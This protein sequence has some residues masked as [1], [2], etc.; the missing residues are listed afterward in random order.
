MFAR[1]RM[2]ALAVLVTAVGLL[3]STSLLTGQSPSSA[4]QTAEPKSA[5]DLRSPQELNAELFRKFQ[6]ELLFLAQKLERSERPEDKERAKVIFAALELAKK[7]NVENQFQK[8]VAGLGKGGTNL[9][10]LDSV[11]GQDAQLTKVLQEILSI[12]M[13]DDAATVLKQERERLEKILAE[14][15]DILRN[16]KT[17]RAMTD[18]ERVE[19]ARIAKDQNQVT[20]RTKELAKRL[21]SEP[22]DAGK[23][24]EGIAK[25][26]PKPEAK[27]GD[28]ESAAKPDTQQSKSSSKDSKGGD[29]MKPGQESGADKKPVGKD[30]KSANGDDKASPE[31][32]QSD[33]A[34]SPRDSGDQEGASK[35][36]ASKEGASKEGKE[37]SSK[38]AAGK[39]GSNKEGHGK[40]AAGKPTSKSDG[41]GQGQGKGQ[42][43]PSPD[44]GGE[45]KGSNAKEGE[46]QQAKQQGGAKGGGQPQPGG[47]PQQGAQQPGQQ[48]Q[49]QQ[50]A[51]QPGRKQLQDAYPHQKSSEDDLKKDQREQA[52]KQQEKAIEQI[53]K[54]IQ[55]LEKKIKQLREE[56]MLK[57]LANLEVRVNRMLAMQIEVYEATKA[58]DSILLKNNGVK[59]TAEVQKSQQQADKEIDIIAEAEKTLKLLESEGTAVAFAR[60]LEE[61]RQD[62]IAVQRRLNDTYVGKDTQEV[63]EN[64]I[65]MLKEMLLALKKAQQDQQQQ[66]KQDQQQQQPQ[67]P[68]DKKLIEQVAELKLIRTLQMNVNSR[69][70]GTGERYK[71]EQASS[72]IIQAE[73][74]Q[75]A[76]KQ[77][78]LQDMVNKIASGSNQ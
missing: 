17:I 6:R 9:Q 73:L 3:L 42:D 36:G 69:T 31:D 65:T 55:E 58:I 70:K 20:D 41:K 35:E 60:V 59:T 14:A 1:S 67:K 44:S 57:L 74:R 39:E 56:E 43:K 13:T 18:V 53:A 11:S 4:P 71:G 77:A 28:D 54:A 2:I 32:K 30:A 63:E 37:G 38:D 33:Q 66:Q 51:Q 50:Q 7:E 49:H 25:A 76:D 24:Q 68:G 29:P 64:V 15:R 40:E 52:T 72:P 22:K 61:V 12:L 78:N 16:Q 48:A 26:E 47:Q 75:L 10:Q 5:T 19:A 23:G 27:S 45:G 34:G 21:G 46:Q 8:M 62:M